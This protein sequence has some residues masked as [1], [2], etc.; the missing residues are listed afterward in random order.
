MADIMQGSFLTS[1]KGD[2][3]KMA[4]VKYNSG[5]SKRMRHAKKHCLDE[6]HKWTKSLR[7]LPTEEEWAE[8]KQ[9]FTKGTVE[10]LFGT[11]DEMLR[12][13]ELKRNPPMF[14]PVAKPVKSTK[15]SKNQ[16]KVQPESQSL[17]QPKEQPIESEEPKMTDAHENSTPSKPA[18]GSHRR[19]DE[20][21][22]ADV[23][24]VASG[25]DEPMSQAMYDKERKRRNLSYM[26]SS[27][28]LAYRFG[29]NWGGVLDAAQLE[30]TDAIKRA[31]KRQAEAQ[32]Q[33]ELQLAPEPAA[34]PRTKSEPAPAVSTVLSDFDFP[35]CQFVSLLRSDCRLSG[36]G[37][38]GAL[39][40]GS[41]IS[42]IAVETKT[43]EIATY[44]QPGRTPNLDGV[45]E[46]TLTLEKDGQEFA[47][48]DP[49]PGVLYLVD[50]EI[51]EAIY[52]KAG[53]ALRDDLVP[54]YV[55][56]YPETQPLG[57]YV[58][59]SLHK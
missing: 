8:N 42:S 44:T 2:D 45:I 21:C 16:S 20:Q 51:Y 38:K 34:Q 13:L 17:G 56:D 58:G 41:D 10:E 43:T 30:L 33:A 19:T 50:G 22:L 28:G 35:S 9:M 26:L 59:M 53:D 57:L 3:G 27:N 25:L 14:M 37:S 18:G 55:V 32:A 7:R 6:A 40:P 47:L 54:V 1:T 39:L 48:P 11:F 12:Q 4:F 5:F 46:V 31:R 36:N 23:R 15:A 24:E 52:K 49:K 29:G